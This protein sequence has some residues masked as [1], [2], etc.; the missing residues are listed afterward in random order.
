MDK[1]GI[2]T[3]VERRKD[4]VRKSKL[5]LSQLLAYNFVSGDLLIT[6]SYSD[7]E[8]SNEHTHA[9]DGLRNW[10]LS[11][12]R[13]RQ[14]RGID[15]RYIYSTE[16]GTGCAPVHY[17]IINAAGEGERYFQQR[18]KCGSI[19]VEGVELPLQ[20]IALSIQIIRQSIKNE[21]VYV[22]RGRVW[23]PSQGLKRPRGRVSI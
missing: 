18:W 15:T 10:L 1:R 5:K 7:P 8:S 20:C 12:R 4:N 2:N 21:R 6:L 13:E 17:V 16:W 11:I 23:V 9:V 22:P 19:T 3:P 14:K